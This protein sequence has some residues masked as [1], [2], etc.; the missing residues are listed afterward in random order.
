MF[1]WAGGNCYSYH[2]ARRACAHGA[3][4]D[5]LRAF[6]TALHERGIR[7]LHVLAHSMGAAAFLG[8]LPSLAAAPIFTNGAAVALG[9]WMG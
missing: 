7:K 4:A 5:D 2:A 3:E 9:V 6:F 8:A 1:S